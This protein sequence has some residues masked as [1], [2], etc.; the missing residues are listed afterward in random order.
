M[1]IYQK[2]TI[3]LAFNALLSLALIIYTFTSLNQLTEIVNSGLPNEIARLNKSVFI[4]YTSDQTLYYDEVLTQS[5]RNYAFTGQ[6]KWKQR[7]LENE[8]KLEHAIKEAQVLGKV[9]DKQNFEELEAANIRLVELER[10]SFEYMDANEAAKAIALLEGEEYWN[11]KKDYLASLED[12]S[13]TKG[14]EIQSTLSN[15]ES[16]V[17]EQS[18]NGANLVLSMKISSIIFILLILGLTWSTTFVF[19]RLVVNRLLTLKEGAEKIREGDFDSKIN[20]RSKDEFEELAIAFNA[21]ASNLKSMTK[22]I[23]YETL[24]RELA[25]Q[26]QSFSRELHDSLGITI[27]S[28]KLQLQELRPGMRIEKNLEKAYQTCMHLLNEAYAQIR[29][30]ANNPVPQTIIRTGLKQSLSKMFSRSEMIFPISIKFITNIQ[31]EDF[32]DEDKASI[33]YLLRELLNNAIKHAECKKINAQIIK[34]DD[35]ILIMFEDDGIGFNVEHINKFPGNG[36]KNLQAR[37]EQLKGQYYFDSEP[38]IGTTVTIELP[39]KNKLHHE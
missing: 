36:F 4:K 33:Y 24:Q 21:M 30:L 26:R 12:Y 1:T 28:L 14:N 8:L 15:I 29:E 34:H 11:L 37:I 2:T 3:F 32:S 23:N 27:S 6:E 7:Y 17:T 18:V 31:E 16:L 22:Q 13:N 19:M 25:N 9:K 35:Q 38:N 39:L 5:A 20:I 10:L